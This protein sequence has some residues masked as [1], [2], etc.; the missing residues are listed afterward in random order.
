MTGIGLAMAGYAC[1][2]VQDAIVKWLVQDLPVFEIL[3]MRSIM[4]MIFAGML[5]GRGVYGAA[6]RSRAKPALLGRGVLI[7]AAWISYYSA[8][9]WLPLAELVTLYFAAPIFVMILSILILKEQVTLARWLAAG[10]GFLGVALA[11]DPTGSVNFIP[12]AMV[13][14]S[15]F[16]WAWTNILVRIISRTEAT[17]T[18][19]IASNFIFALGCA[20]ALPFLWVTPTWTQALL[21]LGLGVAGGAGQ[22]LVFEGFR[23]AP[24][25]AV[26]PFEYSALVWAFVFGFAIWGDIPRIGVVMGASLIIASGVGLLIAE[27]RA[28]A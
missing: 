3:F 24:A 5:A 14:A 22:Y 9:K 21:L 7:L 12:A 28:T 25:S 2:S 23:Y 20:V 11:A 8:A 17:A 16:L 6:L 13:V 18:Q 4:I 10:V 19:M 1:F 27:R 15:A 26:A